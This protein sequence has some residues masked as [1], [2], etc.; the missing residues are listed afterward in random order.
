MSNILWCCHVRGPDNVLAAPDYETALKWADL[1]NALNWRGPRG[2]NRPPA[3][4]ADCLLK[5]VPAVWPWS[6]EEHAASMEKS[7]ATFATSN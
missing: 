1:T 6:A 4:Y 7:I 5:A 2:K 3:S